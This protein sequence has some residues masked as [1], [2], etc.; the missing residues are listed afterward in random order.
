MV[1]LQVIPEVHLLSNTQ[2]LQE[3][4]QTPSLDCQHLTLTN[5][6]VVTIQTHYDT[7]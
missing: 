2:V 1:N 5:F 3:S 4:N 7:E 6:F